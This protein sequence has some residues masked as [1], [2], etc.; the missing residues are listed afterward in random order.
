MVGLLPGGGGNPK[1]FPDYWNTACFRAY[2]Q[3]KHLK[4][5][6]AMAMGIVNELAAPDELLSKAKQWILDGEKPFSLGKK[7]D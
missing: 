6:Q 4:P 5:Q 2:D 3:G 7:K 1:D